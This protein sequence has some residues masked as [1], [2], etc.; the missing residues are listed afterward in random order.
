MKYG[1]LNLGQI[2][3]IVNK[4]G[5]M[6]GVRRLLAGEGRLVYNR[7]L[8]D[9][10]ADAFVPEDWKVESHQKG[11]QFVWSP[12]K[13]KL[14][15][16]PEQKGDGYIEGNKLRKELGRERVMN[17]NLLDCLLKSPELI[18]GEWKGKVV[19]FWGTI[20][21]SSADKLC[22]RYLRFDEGGWCWGFRWLDLGW[23]SDSPAVVAS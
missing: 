22:V 11:G 16:S 10:D 20:Y 14:Y 9:L 5:G 6:E 1:E 19:F 21:R 18:P 2:E 13:V 3:A 4:L 8:V 7:H 15:L 23:S 12:E 17:A